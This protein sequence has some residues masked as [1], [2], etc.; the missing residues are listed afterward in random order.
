MEIKLTKEQY[1]NL[2]KIIHLGDWMANAIHDGSKEDPTDE[3]LEEIEDY[4]Y[5]FAKE[6]GLE[7]FIEY[8]EKHKKYFP[9]N[10][11]DELVQKYID[12]YDDY[13]F[14]DELFYRM[15]DRDFERTYSREEI[16][17]MEIR[18]RF[19]K[20]EPF[21]NKWDKEINDHGIE[22]LEIKGK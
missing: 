9:T 3:K 7:N 21:R 5:S 11:L 18:E 6:F 1:E 22:R 2:I 10:E 13:C 20:E 19:E 15:S 16:S 17:K 8:D 4:I 12:E 14:W